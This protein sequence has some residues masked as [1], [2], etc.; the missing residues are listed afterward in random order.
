MP[1]IK[2]EVLKAEVKRMNRYMSNI[3]MKRKRVQVP[4]RRYLSE[5]EWE[6]L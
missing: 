3:P 1:G 4:E 2:Q 5:K 6:E